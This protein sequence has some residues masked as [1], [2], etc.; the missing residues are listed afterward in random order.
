MTQMTPIGKDVLE[1]R[2]SSMMEAFRLTMDWTKRLDDGGWFWFR[3]VNDCSFELEPGAYWRPSYD[4]FSPLLD[5][6]QEGRAYAD[7]GE[8]DDWKTYYLAQHN[9]IPT[10]LLDWTESFSAALF[11]ALDGWN[12]ST[13]PC[14]WVMRPEYLNEL[15]VGWRGLISPEQNKELE[16]WLPRKIRKG[17]NKVESADGKATYNSSMPLAIYPR[18]GN[19]RMIAQQGTFTIHGT[20]KIKLNKWIVNSASNPNEIICK[21]ILDGWPKEESLRQLQALGIRRHTMYP[22]L[23]NYIQHLRAYYDW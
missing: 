15:S 9:G 20:E 7:I 16:I 12:G 13:T 2:A 4:E 8:L 22:D 17:A 18:K 1:L 19:S 3:G 5:F 14:V 6:V 21:V 23:H 10:R 11:F